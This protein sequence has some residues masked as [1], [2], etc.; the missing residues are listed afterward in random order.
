MEK[1]EQKKVYLSPEIDWWV[2]HRDYLPEDTALST[3]GG[4]QAQGQPPFW[5]LRLL[6]ACAHKKLFVI[7]FIVLFVLYGM[8]FIDCRV[9]R[10]PTKK[11]FYLSYSFLKIRLKYGKIRT[12]S[13]SVI[14][15]YYSVVLTL[16]IKYLTFL[17]AGIYLPSSQNHHQL[18]MVSLN[19][20]FIVQFSKGSTWMSVVGRNVSRMWHV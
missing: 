2:H 12:I 1:Y 10:A 5:A 8:M 19:W 9:F 4:S 11:P 16:H 14:P 20:I 18:C 7:F 15:E 6:D 17:A 13:V 3:K